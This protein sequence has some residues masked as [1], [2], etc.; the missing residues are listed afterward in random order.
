MNN[1]DLINYM[2]K[3]V[4]DEELSHLKLKDVQYIM[5]H[6]KDFTETE[7]D[8]AGEEDEDLNRFIL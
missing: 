4:F 2:I 8:E 5:G 6:L 3:I 7:E 1:E